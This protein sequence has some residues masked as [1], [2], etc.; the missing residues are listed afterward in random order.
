MEYREFIE[1]SVEFIESHN[2]EWD[3]PS[4]LHFMT[5]LEDIGF[6]ENELFTRYLTYS[7]GVL[8][9]L[10]NYL[11]IN[12]IVTVDKT[13][14]NCLSI[15][16]DEIIGYFEQGENET[17]LKL[18]MKIREKCNLGESHI[19]IKS[20]LSQYINSLKALFSLR[21]VDSKINSH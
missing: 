19:K 10:H 12:N 16:S 3:V 17:H 8:M 20:Y 14:A 13:G 15:I 9:A 11:R 7:I 1:K 21:R 4:L 6:E 2:G 18:Y 5:H